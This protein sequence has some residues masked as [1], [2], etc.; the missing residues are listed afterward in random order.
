MALGCRTVLNSTRVV[1]QL[2]WSTALG[3]AM[4]LVRCCEIFREHGQETSNETARNGRLV[5]E[6]SEGGWEEAP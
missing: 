6:T 1:R 3:P 2:G 4:G 5:V